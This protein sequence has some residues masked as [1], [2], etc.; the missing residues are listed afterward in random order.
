MLS[1]ETMKYNKYL[2]NVD[3]FKSGGVTEHCISSFFE[4]FQKNDIKPETMPKFEFSTAL[5]RG[6]PLSYI[7]P[8]AYDSEIISKVCTGYAKNHKFN[9]NDFSE[10]SAI[11]LLI[12]LK[13]TTINPIQRTSSKT[14]DFDV[15]WGKSEIEVEV[16]RPGE[17]DEWSKR[18]SQS[19]KIIDFTSSLKREFSIHIYVVDLLSFEE[20]DSLKSNIYSLCGVDRI[21]EKEKWLV[22]SELPVG[23]PKIIIENKKDENRPTWWPKQVLNGFILSG[24]MAGPN[25]VNPLPRYCV[26]FAC[27]F[28]GYINKAKKKATKFQGT[29]TKPFILIL[30]VNELGNPFGEFKRNLDH[31]FSEWKQISAVFIFINHYSGNEIGWEFQLFINPFAIRRFDDET[32]ETLVEFTERKRAI[33][34]CD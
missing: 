30:D 19:Q 2:E 9:E 14:H 7:N 10:V 22:I 26:K 31:Y 12:V 3:K 16:T 25:E 15:T 24:M 34:Y 18:L 27:P 4:C 21:E 33:K 5:R 8:E 23:D 32:Q 17:K 11:A 13:A 6:L 20:L 28:K 29:R 1:K